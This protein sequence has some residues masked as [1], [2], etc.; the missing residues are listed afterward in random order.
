MTPPDETRYCTLLSARGHEYVDFNIDPYGDADCQ[1]SADNWDGNNAIGDLLLG[2]GER[3]GAMFPDLRRVHHRYVECLVFL[4]SG[5][6]NHRAPYVP[7]PR[8][9]VG[10]LAAVDRVLCR[11]APDTLALGQ[12]FVFVKEPA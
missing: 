10:A 9:L 5:G 7:L 1:R 6:V 11:V 8:A 12:E 3:L 2:D 4:N